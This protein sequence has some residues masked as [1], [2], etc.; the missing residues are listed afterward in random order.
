[1][2]ERALVVVAVLALAALGAA[3]PSPG[4]TVHVTGVEGSLSRTEI[5]RA[6][7]AS[8]FAECQVVEYGRVIR[9]RLHATPEGAIVIDGLQAHEEMGAA[10]PCVRRVVRS[11]TLPSADGETHFHLAVVFPA[12]LLGP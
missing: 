1:V 7:P 11:T 8:A 10:V 12:L 2:A 5:R 3:Q 4:L 6:L 9:L